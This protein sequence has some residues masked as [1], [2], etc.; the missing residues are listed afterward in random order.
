MSP[1]LTEQVRAKAESLGFAKCAIAPVGSLAQSDFYEEW[2]RR[3]FH[4]EMAYMARDP[5]RRLFPEE[6]LPGARSVICVV[7]NYAT[8]H[9]Q[10]EDGVKVDGFEVPGKIWISAFP[11]PDFTFPLEKPG[12][13][14][15]G[16]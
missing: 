13:V 2:I 15:R 10:S 7:Q 8:S 11:F 6:L 5:E 4:G 3:E 1:S 14:F 9:V 16:G 12:E